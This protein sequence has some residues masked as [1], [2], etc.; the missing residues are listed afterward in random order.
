ML[1]SNALQIHVKDNVAIAT[2]KIASGETISINGK[3]AVV[4]KEDITPGHKIAI[5]SISKGDKVYRYGEAIAEAIKDIK[6]GE[7]VHVHNT[8][9]YPR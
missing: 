6:P 1:K 8:K 9:A 4:A 7:W 3:K 5:A 2:Q